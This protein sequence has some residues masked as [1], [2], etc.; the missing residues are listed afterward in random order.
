[1][2]FYVLPVFRIKIEDIKS[3]HA[4]R[5]FSIKAF[6]PSTLRLANKY[7]G[8]FLLIEK[9]QESKRIIIT[10]RK[11][12]SFIDAIKVINPELEYIDEYYK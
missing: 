4:I 9:T 8:K 3:I 11:I 6:Y 12:D 10:P 2:L 5:F 7:T 1:M